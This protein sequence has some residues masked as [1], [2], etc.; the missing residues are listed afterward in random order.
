MGL[1]SRYI[2]PRLMHW[3]M[4]RPGLA[5][6]RRQALAQVQGDVLEIGFGT[7]L[8]L[9]HYPPKARKITALDTN[10]VV[11]ARAEEQLGES[12]IEVER[13]VGSSERLPMAAGSFDSVVSTFSLCSIRDVA[14]ALGEVRRVLRP[15]GRFFFLEH[16][17]SAEPRIARWQH[18]FTP[19][20]RWLGEGCHLDRPIRQL[21]EAAGFQRVDCDEHEF[22]SMGKLGGY[23][24]RGVAMV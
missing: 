4:S 6:E 18:R 11:L 1:Y 22:P 17:L 10:A 8:N 24:Y 5:E 20:T 14:A 2:F 3:S 15:G 9:A 19:I 13:L 16:G 7:G 21:V 23:L 12:A